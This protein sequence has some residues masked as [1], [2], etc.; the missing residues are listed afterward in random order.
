MWEGTIRH[1]VWK[2]DWTQNE[3][4]RESTRTVQVRRLN[5]EIQWWTNARW[6]V[7]TLRWRMWKSFCWQTNSSECEETTVEQKHESTLAWKCALDVNRDA[8]AHLP[9]LL[10]TWRWILAAGWSSLRCLSSSCRLTFG[11][12]SDLHCS[13][14]VC[15]TLSS[16]G[17][18]MGVNLKPTTSCVLSQKQ[19]TSEALFLCERQAA[20]TW[21]LP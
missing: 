1:S 19:F 6:V 20:A 11:W 4:D 13:C 2:V 8:T 7:A 21:L 10:N 9:F 18:E 14:S 16:P 12:L 5:K 3:K 17:D 15:H